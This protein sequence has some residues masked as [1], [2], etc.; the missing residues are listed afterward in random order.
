VEEVGDEDLAADVHVDAEQL[1]TGEVPCPGDGVGGVP[2]GDAE[3]E[4]RVDLAGAHE[5]VGV[6]LDP[7]GRPHEDLGDDPVLGV[8]RGEAVELVEAVDHD[9]ADPGLAG[10][11][12][13]G[14]GLVAAVEDEPLR[15]DSGRE[16]DVQLATGGDIEVHPLLVGQLGH[17]EAQERLR[18]VGHAVAEGIDGL[19]APSP[20]VGLVVDEQGRAEPLGQLDQVAPADGEPAVGGD[21]GGVRQQRPR[22]RPRAHGYAATLAAGALTSPP[23]RRR[24][25]GRGRWPARSGRP[26]RARVAPA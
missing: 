7:R 26:R 14:G 9:P 21:H 18:G 20:Q 23:E 1:H 2:R 6:G 17:R 10:G 5:L 4:L 22:Q 15:R 11:P 25:A 19:P 16:G 12:Q 8:Q 24:R 3:A 13:L